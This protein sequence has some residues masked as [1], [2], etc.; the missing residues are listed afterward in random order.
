M[1]QSKKS[2]NDDN[3]LIKKEDFTS[4]K[5]GRGLWHSWHLAGFR[6]KTRS[7]ILLVFEFILFYVVNM[8]CEICSKHANQFIKNNDILK[9]LLDDSL[10]DTEIINIF[11][12]WLY[13][14]HKAAN[15]HAGKNS[16]SYEDVVSFYMSLERCEDDCAK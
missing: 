11:N 15:N 6:S 4:D 14:F 12:Q 7:D 16:P 10:T 3:P 13:T 1:E 2:I 9:Y 8:H 5:I